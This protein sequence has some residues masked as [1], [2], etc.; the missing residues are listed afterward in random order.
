MESGPT[1][2]SRFE[3]SVRKFPDRLAVADDNYSLTYRQLHGLVLA[4][5]A[6]LRQAGVEGNVGIFLPN[7]AGFLVSF[8][9][10][11]S[12]PATCV[13]LNLLLAPPELAGLIEHAQI[14]TVLTAWPLAEKLP[15]T[16]PR[17]VCLEELLPELLRRASSPPPLPTAPAPDDLAAI[18]YTS[19]TMASPK[20]VMLKH[21]NLTANVAGC[22]R[23]LELDESYVILGL[24][25]T[26]HCFALT[27]TVLLPLSIGA[28][29]VQLSRFSPAALLKAAERHRASVMPAI[30]SIFAALARSQEAGNYDLSALEM[31]IS[32]AEPLPRDVYDEFRARFGR[33]LVQGYGL[34]E[35]SPVVA[36]N[37][38]GDPRPD[39]VGLPLPGLEVQVWGPQ[40]ALPPGEVGQVVVRG[41]SVM[42]GYYRDPEATRAAVDDEGWLRTG[43]LGYFEEQGHLVLCGRQKELIIVAGENVFPAEVEEVLSSHPAVTLVA[44]VG[45]KDTVRGEVPRAYVV[46]EPGAEATEKGLR[47]FCRER[48]AP[49]KVPREVVLRE[50][51]PLTATGKVFKRKLLED[52]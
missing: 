51:L 36:V 33:R 13:P 23:V 22:E 3:T 42:A 18:I 8:F 9:G 45:V 7:G 35:C 41:E 20:G 1:I 4:L 38:P 28:A 26:F 47:Q 29:T 25:P 48:L 12:L 37:P 34:T 15:G 6:W 11:L 5:G 50:E 39:T 10:V 31:C 32:G 44:V 52:E 40:G 19:G 16:L 24:L 49:F 21:R 46:L 2:W 14:E 27:V 30:P 17:V 43:D